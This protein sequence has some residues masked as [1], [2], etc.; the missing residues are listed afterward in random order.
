MYLCES[1]VW[2]RSMLPNDSIYDFRKKP[3]PERAQHNPDGYTLTA[4]RMYMTVCSTVTSYTLQVA[5][6]MAAGGQLMRPLLPTL[7]S[8]KLTLNWKGKI[9]S[10]AEKYE[11]F[12][13]NTKFYYKANI[14]IT[15][16]II[17]RENGVR[18]TMN[19]VWNGAVAQGG[20]TEDRHCCKVS[21]NILMRFSSNE[22]DVKTL[23]FICLTSQLQKT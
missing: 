11:N 4:S 8:M 15:M 18:T 5:A 14:Y 23:N 7:V 21:H 9:N 19:D 17:R 20:R 12:K 10:F 6:M 22:D 13:R 2:T 1:S 16:T 3:L